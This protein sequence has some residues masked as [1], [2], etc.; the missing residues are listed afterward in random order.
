LLFD[1]ASLDGLG[2]KRTLP[3]KQTTRQPKNERFLTDR[4]ATPT[5]L[6]TGSF[7]GPSGGHCRRS[8]VRD[9]QPSSFLETA[10]PW[11]TQRAI[12]KRLRCYCPIP[13]ANQ[14]DEPNKK[15]PQG[16]GPTWHSFGI[17][18]GTVN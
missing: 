9:Y 11:V 7:K 12:L 15:S 18:E 5:V 16:G 8:L 13:A 14:T 6:R 4:R 2:C 10:G 3:R 17:G 1:M